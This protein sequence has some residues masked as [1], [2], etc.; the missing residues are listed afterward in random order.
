MFVDL[1]QIILLLTL[2]TC[3]PYVG[4]IFIYYTIALY[5]IGNSMYL[6]TSYSFFNL[7]I[8]S[9]LVTLLLSPMQLSFATYYYY[10]LFYT[11]NN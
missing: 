6:C 7:S 8:L 5:S 3:L 10:R 9:C 4:T 2:L 11:L 1:L